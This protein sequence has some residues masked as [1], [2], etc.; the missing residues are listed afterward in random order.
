MAGTPT[1]APTVYPYRRKEILMR[2]ARQILVNR[3][4]PPYRGSV[5]LINAMLRDVLHDLGYE[6]SCL[7]RANRVAT[8]IADWMPLRTARTILQMQSPP[9]ADVEIRDNISIH[10]YPLVRR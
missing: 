10:A 5:P 2:T 4:G 8:D 3:P 9:A 6:T 7:W 1:T